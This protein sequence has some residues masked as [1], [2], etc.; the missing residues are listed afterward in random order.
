MSNCGCFGVYFTQ[1][2]SWFVLLQDAL[3]LLYA[4]LLLRATRRIPAR[5]PPGGV[6]ASR[7]VRV[8]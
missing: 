4:G 3:M 2:L 7:D 5:E 6:E 8:P 1:P